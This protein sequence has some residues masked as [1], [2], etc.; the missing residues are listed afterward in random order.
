MEL[1]AQLEARGA[2]LDLQWIPRDS[3]AEADRLADGD[4]DGFSPA[5]RVGG[6]ISQMQWMVL[7][8]LLEY[9]REVH[10]ARKAQGEAEAGTRKRPGSLAG[11]RLRDKE[12][13]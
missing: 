10:G 1:S 12:P 13:W 9:G 7:D 6:C 8:R 2:E 4:Y 11:G 3:N 5:N